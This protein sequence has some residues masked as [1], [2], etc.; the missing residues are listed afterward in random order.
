MSHGSSVELVYNE[1]WIAVRALCDQL[2]W[3]TV[4]GVVSTRPAPHSPDASKSFTPR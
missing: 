4:L 2:D 1:F 3:G